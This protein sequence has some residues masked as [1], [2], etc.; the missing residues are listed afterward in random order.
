MVHPFLQHSPRMVL[1]WVRSIIQ[2]IAFLSEFRRAGP[3]INNINNIF[4][5]F[6]NLDKENR[7]STKNSCFCLC[8]YAEHAILLYI[9]K[10]A[11]NKFS[12][13]YYPCWRDMQQEMGSYTLFKGNKHNEK[14]GGGGGGWLLLW[15]GGKKH[16]PVHVL[17]ES[18]TNRARM[19]FQYLEH[20]T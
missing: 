3:D 11:I 12:K 7:P 8:I 6:I 1:N 16:W 18:K 4:D 10:Q 17:L 14:R 9:C 2:H 15:M 13:V 5:L 20:K 19:S